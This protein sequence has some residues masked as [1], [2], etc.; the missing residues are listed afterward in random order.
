MRF[1]LFVTSTI[2]WCTLSQ[3][4]MAQTPV[5]YYVGSFDPPTRG[6]LQA[7]LEAKEE[8]S[9][10]KVYVTVNYNTDKDF[11]CSV[12]E[13]I[14]MLEHMLENQGLDYEVVRQPIEGQ[15]EF[16][17]YLQ[18]RHEERVLG[19]FGED[20]LGKN[21]DIHGEIPG[22]EYIE[23]KR[24]DIEAA[25]SVIIHPIEISADG[26]SSSK[27]R[28]L[29]KAG[30]STDKI[31]HERVRGLIDRHDF[32]KHILS[33]EN[34][35]F[36]K[37]KIKETYEFL[38]SIQNDWNLSHINLNNILIKQTQSKQAIVDKII[39]STIS[40]LD[41]K[42][43]KEIELRQKL[44]SHLN[45]D[46]ETKPLVSNK[47]A[48]FF[49]GSFEPFHPGQQELLLDFIQKSN[50]EK[51]YLGVLNESPRKKLK[52]PSEERAKE[53]M[54]WVHSSPFKNK[55]EVDVFTFDYEDLSPLARSIGSQ[56]SQG[57]TTL[58]GKNVFESNYHLL[59]DIPFLRFAVDELDGS[60]NIDPQKVVVLNDCNS[61]FK[62]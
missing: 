52:T 4:T 2:L 62:I 57:V 41:L 27:A 23:V 38:S 7:I 10:S 20:T 9:L 36:Q 18:R 40:Q 26:V 44:E 56:H 43:E 25:T 49:L 15:V 39:R 35:E 54:K 3:S 1:F 6:H 22:F 13:R 5:G 34:A 8:F 14:N 58:F 61:G 28:K 21:I 11:H 47:K 12:S 42:I 59:K 19:I 48:G 53:I 30:K 33:A 50:I 17:K 45:S 32:Y 51:I 37:E 16:V 31:L 24:P 29:I 46:F 60:E 55:I